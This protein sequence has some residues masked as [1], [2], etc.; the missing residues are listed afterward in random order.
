MCLKFGEINIHKKE[1][2]KSKTP[3]D[4]TWIDTNKI[5]A[6]DR[7]ELECDKYYIGY[8]DG[9]FVRPLCIILPQM[10]GFIRYLDGKRKIVLFLREDEEI[11]VRY[12]K[13]SKRITKMHGF[14]LDNQSDYDRKCLKTKLKSYCFVLFFCHYCFFKK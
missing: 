6:S 2:H 13:V 9:K 3:I 1:F 14:K 12:S 11:I 10:R 7:F 8:K 4:L 5:V